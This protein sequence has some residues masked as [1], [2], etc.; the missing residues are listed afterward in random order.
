M[1]SYVYRSNTHTGLGPP[2]DVLLPE[3]WNTLSPAWLPSHKVGPL[4]LGTPLGKAELHSEEVSLGHIQ[5][6][7]STQHL[8]PE[9][10]PC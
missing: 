9:N 5:N 1:E 8:L 3:L 2:K 4:I 10:S 7:A 6:Q